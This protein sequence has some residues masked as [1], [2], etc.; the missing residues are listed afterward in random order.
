MGS[1]RLATPGFCSFAA[2]AWWSMNKAVWAQTDAG[3]VSARITWIGI[4]F[5][6]IQPKFTVPALIASA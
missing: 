6:K 3:T 2:G 5:E 1:L 4:G